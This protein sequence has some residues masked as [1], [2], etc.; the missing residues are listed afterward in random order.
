MV[1]RENDQHNGLILNEE[2]TRVIGD[3]RLTVP[4]F[5]C[6]GHVAE[7]FGEA[8]VDLLPLQ[9]R[10][11]E[12][13]GALRYEIAL[14]N[15]FKQTTDFTR[16]AVAKVDSGIVDGLAE[17]GLDLRSRK[18]VEWKL[19]GFVPSRIFVAR[20]ERSQPSAVPI[21]VRELDRCVFQAESMHITSYISAPDFVCE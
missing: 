5:V 2:D 3:E 11:H 8:I 10:E 6:Y 12:F 18:L 9:G 7:V 16:S 13:A 19:D 4:S 1:P 15:Q 17:C 20:I 21:Q 14:L